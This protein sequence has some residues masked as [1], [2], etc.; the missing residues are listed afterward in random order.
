MRNSL[1]LA[2]LAGAAA[3]VS[4]QDLTFIAATFDNT[5]SGGTASDPF[6][7]IDAFSTATS[8]FLIGNQPI[9]VAYDGANLY[10]GGARNGTPARLAIAEISDFFSAQGAKNVPGSDV[11]PNVTGT[12]EFSGR[13]YTGMDWSDAYG[14]VATLDKGSDAI[15]ADGNPLA[16]AAQVFRWNR[17]NPGD[18]ATTLQAFG[19]GIRGISGPAYDYGFNGAGFPLSDGMMGPAV[20]VPVL[21]RGAPFGLDAASMLPEDDIYGP[22]FPQYSL[23]ISGTSTTWRDIDIHPDTG[24]VVA[25]AN[26]FA[27]MGDR[28]Q[29]NGTT[30]LRFITPPGGT[31]SSVSQNVEIIHNPLGRDDFLVLNDRASSG[32]FQ[33]FQNTVL[34]Y[35]LQGNPLT[36]EIVLP[37]GTPAP[38]VNGANI[39]SFYWHE[40]DQLLFVV[41]GNNR[42][43]YALTLVSRCDVDR[44][45][46]L[47]FF[48]TLAFLRLYDAGNLAADFDGVNGL[49]PADLSA[50]AAS[51]ENGCN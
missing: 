5:L 48:D 28:T 49:T 32:V 4:A 13:G 45:G 12:F 33:P 42:D 37:D 30:N 21:G 51:I 26:N 7:D 40:P 39:Y 17:T 23:F 9:S 8:P 16:P 2:V 44:S 36:Y 11:N 3:A 29:F 46:A 31:G 43:V 6:D 35:D 20:A 10:I 38:V 41:D 1:I 19:E 24:F 18:F 50:F 34:F 15:V 25:R 22:D 27:I 14:L 47:D